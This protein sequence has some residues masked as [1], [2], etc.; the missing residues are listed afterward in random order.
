MRHPEKEVLLYTNSNRYLQFFVKALK[1]R[2]RGSNHGFALFFNVIRLISE[3]TFF[4]NRC[5]PFSLHSFAAGSRGLSGFVDSV[6]DRWFALFCSFSTAVGYCSLCGGSVIVV[7]RRRA[8]FFS[9]FFVVGRRLLRGSTIFF[10]N[11]CRALFCLCRLVS[12]VRLLRGRNLRANFW[13]R[14]L[15]TSH[16]FCLFHATVLI[17]PNL[18]ALLSWVFLC[19]RLHM[20]TLN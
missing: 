20:H 9:R 2:G 5:P 15:N 4:R 16:I 11:S 7:V 14:G 6:V 18:L 12:I 3:S 17:K 1:E 19:P 10:L 8:L 13:Q